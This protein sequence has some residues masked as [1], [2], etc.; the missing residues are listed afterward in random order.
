MTMNKAVSLVIGLLL[1]VVLVLSGCGNATTTPA[2]TT[3]TVPPTTTTKPPV[4]TTL[5]PP[6]TIV[7][8][9]APPTSTAPATTTSGQKKGGTLVYIT[10]AG[11]TVI[12]VPILLGID[13]NAIG[14]AVPVIES[15]VSYDNKG[16]ANPVLAE[17]W[18]V[19]TSAKT[20]TFNI[21]KGV[22][23]SDGTPCDA[24]AVAWNL[25][26]NIQAKTSAA[27]S[28]SSVAVLDQYTVLLKLIEYKATALAA[29]DGTAGMI[30]SPTAYK[31]NGQDWAKTHPIGTGPFML[32]NFVRDSEV[33]Y[34]KNPNYWQSGKPYLDGLKIIVISD[35]TTARMTLEAGQA[36]VL[37]VAAADT[38]QALSAKGYKIEQRPGTDMVLIPDSKTATSPFAK[39][40]VREAAEYAI[41]RPSIASTL[42]YGYYQPLNQAA[43]PFQ[44]G[45]NAKLTTDRPYNV[46]TA[47]QKLID[48]G[49]PAGTGPTISITT[50]SSFQT[51]IVTAMMNYLNAA[52]FK[53][54]INT[55]TQA[56]WTTQT[57]TGW[58]SLIWVTQGATDVEYVSF[59]D[60]YYASYAT[61]YPSLLKPTAIT[62]VI[63]SAIYEPDY[64]KRL[65]LS[66]QA[67]AMMSDDCTTINIDHQPGLF[68]EKPYVMNANFGTLTGTG[69]RWDCVNVWLNK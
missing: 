17:S 61:R 43:A 50:S 36:D 28:W 34:V 31:L 11:P 57:N 10:S 30:I 67:V 4:T 29:F 51:D 20:I 38:T 39:K 68:I 7:N 40:G 46:A 47:K 14:A 48:A 62:D 66:Q 60:R 63:S 53:C 22:N 45:Y 32:T 33:D 23:F 24:A 35:A 59:L 49:Y 52:G 6:T 42:G 5:A 3:T 21:R 18:K 54:T 1:L 15:L 8:N 69:F 58:N 27:V 16:V 65:T 12:G 25:D 44:G 55:V 26:Q 41:D 2:A 9:T 37:T 56:V 19:D 13:A 64:A